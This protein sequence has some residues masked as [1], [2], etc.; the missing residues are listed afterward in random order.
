MEEDPKGR[1]DANLSRK[2]PSMELVD[3]V[4]SE[5]SGEVLIGKGG[6]ASV[7][8]VLRNGAVEALKQID[9]DL[10]EVQ[11]VKK[12]GR[13]FKKLFRELLVMQKIYQS[14][15]SKLLKYRAYSVR[16][17]NFNCLE[18]CF[19]SELM[20]EDLHSYALK[21]F[22]QLTVKDKLLLSLRIAEG[23]KEL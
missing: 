9:V 16:V 20:R 7:Y 2:S 21:N 11:N 15:S 6:Y 22:A 10:N 23:I 4:S 5:I 8:R 12:M 14:E 3:R 18:V 19:F 17:N 1:A 13:F